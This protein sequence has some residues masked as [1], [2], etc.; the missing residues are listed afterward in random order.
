MDAGLLTV[1]DDIIGKVVSTLNFWVAGLVV[2]I[3]VAK[4]GDASISLDQPA[5][6][7]CLETLTDDAVLDCDVGSCPTDRERLVSAPSEGDVIEDLIPLAQVD[8]FD[9]AMHTMLD[10]SA[11][12]AASLPEVPPL[13]IL[14][15]T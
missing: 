14:I 7:M 2:D 13:P 9:T 4:E 10:P 5:T 6:R 15:R 11:R 3:E 8:D 12:V 1:V